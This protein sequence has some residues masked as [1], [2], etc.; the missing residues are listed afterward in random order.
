LAGRAR[1]EDACVVTMPEGKAL[2]QTVDILAPLVNDAY[3][4]GRIAAANA[5]SDVY[6]MGGTPWC[7]MNIACFPSCFVSEQPELLQAI[8]RGGLDTLTEAGAVLVGGHT[9]DDADIKYGLSVS[10]IIHPHCI[11]TN[12]AL[13]RG[14]KLLLTKPLGSGILSTGIKAQWDD[15]Q[16]SEAELCHWCG[17]LNAGGAALIRALEL[18]A[19]TDVTGFGL[20]GHVL[21]MALASHT[22]VQL[23][24]AALPLFDAALDYARNGLIPASSHSN[25]HYW[26]QHCAIEKSV[27][28]ERE[29]IIF[30]VQTSGGLVL[31][32]PPHKVEQACALLTASGDYAAII[33]EV[34]P[35][36]NDGISLH[37]I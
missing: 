35:Q 24:S 17:K 7:A 21:E 26:A 2:V 29:S 1:N 4:F 20:G 30:D 15:W 37:I 27:S 11:A 3:A 10:G 28:P 31:A 23:D 32:V 34:L 13:Q 9:V 19:A 22:C 33:G 6:A 5:L 36:R 14:D 25:R 16:H 8:L 12:D 18:R